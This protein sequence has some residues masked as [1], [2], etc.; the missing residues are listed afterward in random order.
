MP[1]PE[2]TPTSEPPTPVAPQTEKGRAAEL[3]RRLGNQPPRTRVVSVE[4]AVG[5]APKGVRF[6]MEVDTATNTFNISIQPDSAEGMV[7]FLE[8]IRW[9][10]NK[11][12]VDYEIKKLEAKPTKAKF[13]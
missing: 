7:G 9:A 6:V 1:E 11:V 4:Q 13:L 3:R 12:G 2:V 5:Q 8:G 10:A